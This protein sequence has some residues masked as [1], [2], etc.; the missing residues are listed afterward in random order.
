[1]KKIHQTLMILCALMLGTC[2][3]S[4]M[5]ACHSGGLTLNGVT[6]LG[7]GQYQIDMT[8]ACGAGRTASALGADQNTATYGF[9]LS[10]ATLVGYPATLTSP[11]TN[12]IYTAYLDAGDSVL[13]YD[14]STEWWACVNNGC[15]P[16]TTVEKSISI[17][18]QGLPNS[19]LCLGMEGGGNPYAGCQGEEVTVY[20]KCL[21]FTTSA[22]ADVT[23]YPGSTSQSCTTISASHAGSTGTVAYLWSTGATTTSINVCP[24]ATTT[25]TVSISNDIGCT[26]IEEVV[27]T[28]IPCSNLIANA[29]ADKNVYPAY[30]P[31]ACTNV[32]AS[33]SGGSGNYSYL[34]STGA[35]TTT[36]NV[37]PSATTTYT[38]TVTD[39][40]RGCVSTDQVVV[41]VKNISCASGKVNVCLAGRTRCILTS[42]VPTYLSAGATLGACGSGKTDFDGLGAE[43]ALETSLDAGPNPADDHT[44]L[45]VTL[46]AA[47]H[48][49]LSLYD[50]NG[51]EVKTI[52]NTQHD[53]GTFDTDVDVSDLAPGLYIIRMQH[54]D[55][56]LTRKLT[57]Q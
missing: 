24:S 1:M 44:R 50:I 42:Q 54:G 25:Y 8:F 23:I 47:A 10:G 21:G 4:T 13:V 37:C 55:Q 29:G 38:V 53:A 40:V 46:D 12:A 16:I 20:P 45:I 19:I 36:I 51:R 35:T 33:A 14:N 2:L 48:V 52:L 43:A 27:V 41:N 49:K 22:S 17:V 26:L 31:N 32:T 56:A 39:N 18:T 30:T 11:N 9:I 7:S 6:D 15:G 34:W 57:V 28:A 3:P 5:Q